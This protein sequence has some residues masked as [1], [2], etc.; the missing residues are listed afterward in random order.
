MRLKNQT[1]T[2][3]KTMSNLKYKKIPLESLH[4]EVERILFGTYTGTNEIHAIIH[5]TPDFPAGEDPV[6]TLMEAKMVLEQFLRA[7][8]IFGRLLINPQS[9]QGPVETAPHISAIGQAP[10]DGTPAALWLWM[11]QGT[12][13]PAYTHT[14]SCGESSPTTPPLLQNYKAS[15]S[16]RGLNIADHCLRTWFFV[17]DID[18][19]YHEMVVERRTFFEQEGL[20][21]ATH[22][23]A[24]TG[25]E[26]TPLRPSDIVQ[27]ET[28][29]VEGLQQEQITY[30]KGSSHLNPT[31]EYGVTFE[32]GTRIEYGDRCH[33]IIS[34]TASIDNLGQILYPE[35]ATQQT[36]RMLENVQVLLNEGGATLRDLTHAL[37]YIR[38]DEDY[39]AIRKVIESILPDV[40]RVYL[41]A[42][43]C[44]PGWLVEMEGIA[45]IP[46]NNTYNTF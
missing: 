19:N 31:H 2:K 15:L 36:Y 27:M 12:P 35:D 37:I 42:P 30:L 21:P 17:K 22:Y 4:V 10:L 25:I 11:V 39:P 43:V 34:G 7:S 28:Y 33:L 45:A 26:G 1:K 44:R 16:A 41:H 18:H 13:N 24:S 23:I 8:T 20:T 3:H 40:P 46:N 38:R 6:A 9:I 14:F 5:L 29:T 32:R